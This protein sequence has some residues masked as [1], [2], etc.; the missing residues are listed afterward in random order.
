MDIYAAET[1]NIWL[2]LFDHLDDDLY[3]GD[4]SY[5]DSDIP[6]ICL[7]FR[8]ASDGKVKTTHRVTSS[9]A[10]GLQKQTVTTTVTRTSQVASSPKRTALA[11]TELESSIKY[12]LAASKKSSNYVEIN[13]FEIGAEPQNSNGFNAKNLQEELRANTANAIADIQD[14]QAYRFGVDNE[15]VGALGFIERAHAEL[16][17]EQAQDERE[18]TRLRGIQKEVDTEIGVR[19][20]RIE[21]EVQAIKRNIKD[22]EDVTKQTQATK[23]EKTNEN[24]KLNDKINIPEDLK[25]Q[26]LSAEAKS[27]RQDNSKLKTQ[28]EKNTSDFIKESAD[29]DR[30][31][32]EHNET[33][34]AYND[35]IYKY[36]GLLLQTEEARRVHSVNLNDVKHQINDLDAQSDRFEQRIQLTDIDLEYFIQEGE[37]LR[38][39]LSHS[40]KVYSENITELS[41]ILTEQQREIGQ[42]R[43]NLNNFENSNR[44]LENEVEKQKLDL[45]DHE[46]EMDSIRSF[47]YDEKAEKLLA[48]LKRVEDDRRRHQ[49]ELERAHEA[50]TTKLALF[51][52]EA[53]ERRKQKEEREARV[54]NELNKLHELQKHI[55]DLQNQLDHLS[56]K[57]V[58]DSNKDTVGA[59]L[60]HEKETLN[61][62]LRWALDERDIS[63]NDMQEAIALLRAK[64]QEIKDQER[65]IDELRREIDSLRRLIE[66]KKKII[67]ELEAEIE[68]CNE[69]ID[70]LRKR[71]RDLDAQILELRRALADREARVRH[72]ID[73]LGEP[74]EIE[75][76]Y[77]A[78]KGDEVDE[79]LAMYL[80]NCPVPVK[81]LGG[82]FYLFGTRKIYAKIMNGKLVVRVGGG[83]MFISEFITSYSDQEIIKLT[84]L[85]EKYGVDSIWDLDLEEIYYSKTGNNSPGRSP[86]NLD[87]SPK[88]G[89]GMGSIKK[90][91]K[92]GANASMNGSNRTGKKFNASAIVRQLE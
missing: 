45:Q 24:K 20:S 32:G 44:A 79:M 63:R 14:E 50:L 10:K 11:S 73:L 35:T 86:N 4:F 41:N 82:G 38:K 37:S 59:S 31:L 36:H 21:A 7:E 17:G 43:D 51:R 90:T 9:A 52:D 22:V 87:K 8:A 40:D 67:T 91:V 28:F 61:L 62:K 26:G 29:R 5:D 57:I 39:E 25:E 76:N 80:Q 81:R 15:R 16:K 27:F 48:D 49:D 92:K 13:E 19:K 2:T 42:L 56:N 64:Q 65:K 75:I 69:R 58:S 77:K 18:T 66:E 84:K 85:C 88:G 71:I 1:K 72:L 89:F 74:K 12:K 60:E 34:K 33:V 46:K 53:A 70:Y 55:N 68:R 6:R 78:M 3:D 30:I 23:V 47:G 54:V 83:Y